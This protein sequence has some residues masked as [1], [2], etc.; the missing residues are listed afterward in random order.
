MGTLVQAYS[1][2]GK[3]DMQI[4]CTE[5]DAAFTGTQDMAQPYSLSWFGVAA[6]LD[7]QHTY[8]DYQPLART[9]GVT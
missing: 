8:A 4:G 5:P 7:T 1:T 9:K 6:W 3:L 2:C